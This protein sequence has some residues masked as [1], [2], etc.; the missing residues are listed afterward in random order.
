MNQELKSNVNWKWQLQQ[1]LIQLNWIMQLNRI[2][3]CN[4]T[5]FKFIITQLN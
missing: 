4:L 3:E 5:D 2:N 1:S